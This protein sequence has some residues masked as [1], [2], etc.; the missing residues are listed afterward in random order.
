MKPHF[1]VSSD[2]L[3]ADIRIM[4]SL[5]SESSLIEGVSGAFAEGN[6][7]VTPALSFSPH[8]RMVILLDS[9]AVLNSSL[10]SL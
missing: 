4:H 1:F 3:M 8:S 9:P 10:T 2:M 6:W 7:T 5:I